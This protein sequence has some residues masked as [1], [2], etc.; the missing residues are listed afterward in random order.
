[1]GV[2]RE[3]RGVPTAGEPITTHFYGPPPVGEGAL[4]WS[5]RPP[6]D[7]APDD[8][9][10]QPA[11]ERPPTPEATPGAVAGLARRLSRPRRP[12]PTAGG[13]LRP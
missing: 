3:D 8:R 12:R 10:A 2:Q 13:A 9:Y 5:P 1:M 7:W 6:E 11:A 4:Q